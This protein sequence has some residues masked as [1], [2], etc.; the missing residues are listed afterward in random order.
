MSNPV[1]QAS[2]VSPDFQSFCTGVYGSAQQRH[3][4]FRA[5]ST[6]QQA[7]SVADSNQL[8]ADHDLSVV[9]LPDLTCMVSV[10]SHGDGG[11]LVTRWPLQLSPDATPGQVQ[12]AITTARKSMLRLLTKQP[13]ISDESANEVCDAKAKIGTMDARALTA[14]QSYAPDKFTSAALVCINSAIATRRQQLA[15]SRA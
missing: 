4:L 13:K 8:D 14:A 15:P 6:A 3:S 10:I 12:A 9:A 5:I 11:M 2:D 1:V 7:F